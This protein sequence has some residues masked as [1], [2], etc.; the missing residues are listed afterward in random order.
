[1]QLLTIACLVHYTVIGAGSKPE[2][3]KTISS[4]IRH[5]SE[6]RVLQALAADRPDKNGINDL[7]DGIR[8]IHLAV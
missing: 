6:K 4:Y 3:D 7:D 5:G 2:K 8:P 1:M